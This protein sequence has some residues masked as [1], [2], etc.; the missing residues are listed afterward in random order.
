MK[1]IGACRRRLLALFVG[2]LVAGASVLTAGLIA[3]A[4]SAAA[5]NIAVDLLTV[6]SSTGA[7]QSAYA[8]ARV[9]STTG[10]VAVQAITIAVRNASGAQFDFPGAVGANIPTTGYTFTSGTRTFTAGTYTAF[11]AVQ[12]NSIWYNLTPTKSFTIGGPSSGVVVDSLTLPTPSPGQSVTASARLHGVSGTVNVQAVTIAARSGTGTQADFTGA[13]AASIPTGGYTFTSGAQTFAA[14]S[15]DVFV[16][17]QVNGTWFNLDPHKILVSAAAAPP[18]ATPSLD[19]E[20]NGPAGQNANYEHATEQYWKSDN[21]WYDGCT[22][23]IAQYK[24][25]HA[26]L[27]GAGNLVLT[28]DKN[29]DSTH[30]GT[31]ACQF[32]SSRLTMQDWS[33]GGVPTFARAG[34]HFEAKMK[35]PVGAG[36]WPAFW[37]VGDQTE[38]TGAPW[39]V[40]GEID[41]LESK[42]QNP[43]TAFEYA[44]GGTGSGTTV[45]RF[46]SGAGYT[47]P[48][49]TIADWHVYSVDWDPSANGYIKWSVDNKPLKVLTAAAAG[50]NWKSFQGKHSVIL[51]L[52]VGGDFFDGNDSTAGTTFPAKMYVDYVKIYDKPQA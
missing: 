11:V 14:G 35:L 33:N 51:N 24:E 40:S 17:V 47:L 45:N 22:G 29:L 7:G 5:P 30:C 34:G 9:H 36:L 10:T 32:A 42:G 38:A 48:S 16:A 52:A 8:S 19:F 41:V 46:D 49:G 27:D 12:V 2:I 21:C 15:Y 6:P 26:R 18:A 37:T 25:D 43:T 13:K 44:H 1:S 20:F 4:A 28:A 3:P 23:T 50:A 39:P 31:K